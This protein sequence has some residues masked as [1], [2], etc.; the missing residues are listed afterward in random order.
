M[1]YNPFHARG[2]CPEHG[3]HFAIRAG[4]SLD[5][6][7]QALARKS[8]S[9]NASDIAAG[10]SAGGDWFDSAE[11]F[12]PPRTGWGFPVSKFSSR[13]CFHLARRGHCRGRNVISIA[14]ASDLQPVIEWNGKEKVVALI[15]AF[16]G[17]V[18]L[19]DNMLLN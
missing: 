3:L 2:L 9:R 7:T 15:A 8:R 1:E 11:A 10:H 19:I 17:D 14:R 16:Q 4:A 18:R 13:H 6:R 12:W 5:P